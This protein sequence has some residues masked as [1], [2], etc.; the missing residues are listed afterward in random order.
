MPLKPFQSIT[1]T[2][3]IIYNKDTDVK[4]YYPGITKNHQNYKLRQNPHI[5]SNFVP[6]FITKND[7]CKTTQK[8]SEKFVHTAHFSKNLPT[9]LQKCPLFILKSGREFSLK[10]QWLQRFTNFTVHFLF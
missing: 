10:F 3:N 5:V 1:L 9:F 2:Y 7:H 8:K 6:N 4:P